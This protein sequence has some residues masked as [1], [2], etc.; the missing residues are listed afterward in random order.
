MRSGLSPSA[1][2]SRRAVS[3]LGSLSYSRKIDPLTEL[4]AREKVSRRPL[5]ALVLPACAFFIALSLASGFYATHCERLSRRCSRAVLMC[6]CGGGRP[7][8]AAYARFLP[9]RC[10]SSPCLDRSIALS[11]AGRFYC[12]LFSALLAYSLPAAAPRL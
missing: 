10:A 12:N 3:G 5:L 8:A 2:D 11:Q 4:L 6:L 7:R 1:T 9:R